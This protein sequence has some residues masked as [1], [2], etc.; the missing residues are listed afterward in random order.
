MAVWPDY[1]QA[2]IRLPWWRVA[3]KLS[4]ICSAS[5]RGPGDRLTWVDLACFSNKINVNVNVFHV[6]RSPSLKLWPCQGHS[7]RSRSRSRSLALIY[8][9]SCHIIDL[10]SRHQ[11]P[12]RSRSRSFILGTNK[13]TKKPKKIE[14]LPGPCLLAWQSPTVVL[15]HVRGTGSVWKLQCH[16][17]GFRLQASG[18]RDGLI[19]HTCHGHDK[20]CAEQYAGWLQSEVHCDF[21][22]RL[23]LRYTFISV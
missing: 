12:S 6:S 10:M 1:L 15:R 4:F 2:P 14:E 22:F 7:L 23:N 19:L 13:S 8:L 3:L 21:H 20:T 18:F 5:I 9:K 17:L 11:P 16:K